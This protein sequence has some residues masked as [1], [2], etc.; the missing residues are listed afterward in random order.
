MSDSVE[1]FVA[2]VLLD[3]FFKGNLP[4]LP[5]EE[6][7]GRGSYLS[8]VQH[9]EGGTEKWGGKFLVETE[10][11]NFGQYYFSYYYLFSILKIIIKEV[12]AGKKTIP[13]F[14][15]IIFHRKSSHLPGQNLPKQAKLGSVH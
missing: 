9:W 1:S 15:K 8:F 11:N 2:G 6:M 5:G 3:I 7:K 14:Q 10:K 12:P 13:I 4:G